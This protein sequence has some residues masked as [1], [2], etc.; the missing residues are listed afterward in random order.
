MVFSSTVF[1]YIFFPV[2]FILYYL[3]PDKNKNMIL[4]FFSLLFYAW[5][6]PVFVLVM[7]LSILI[8][9]CFG[10][11]I[12]FYNSKMSYKKSKY[13]LIAGIVSNISILFYFKYFNFF[14][15]N[16]NFLQNVSGNKEFIFA[17]V[18]LP[19]G[20]SFFTFQAMSYIIDL[21]KNKISVQKNIK[22]LALY[23]SLFP[24]LI[25]GPIVRYRSIEKQLI[26]RHYNIYS[27]SIGVRRFIAGLTKKVF[28]ANTL[29]EIADKIFAL[30]VSEFSQGAAWVGIVCY[31]FQIYFD[32]SGYSDM[33]IGL[34]RIF[35]F[36]FME[37]FNYPY[38]SNT[39]TEFWRRWHI[40]LS[41]WFRDYL[42]FPLGGNRISKK[43]TYFN[44]IIVF[45]VTG[46]WHGAAWNF[47]FWGLFHGMFLIF[48]KKFFKFKK[49]NILFNF[50]TL[51]VVLNSWVLFRAPDLKYAVDYFE[52]MYF[53]I[54]TDSFIYSYDYFMTTKILIFLILAAI[55]STPIIKI[56]LR[57]IQKFS[58]GDYIERFV[59]IILI[60]LNI[61]FVGASTYNPFI[62]FR[63]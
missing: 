32:F 5:G 59:Y 49:K 40:S 43:R 47:L 19:I 18:A 20:I 6:E 33:A 42:Y 15:G 2:V 28:F 53:G 52:K 44:L 46:F 63:F 45:I 4:L 56:F 3:F 25:A 61:I 54:R 48:E 7:F 11:I 58:F 36:R 14:M 1:L 10:R 17:E 26:K 16:L 29:G 8:N 31:S 34:G 27:I 55:F 24:Q 51:F 50:Y 57:N 35:G 60:Y 41:T 23:I 38:I 39:I 30:N 62:Y 9:Y 13:A 37:N 21:Y 22:D 12:H